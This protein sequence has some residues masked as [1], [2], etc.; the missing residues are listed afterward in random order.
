[1]DLGGKTEL[2]LGASTRS[3]TSFE[4]DQENRIL[5]K[6]EYLFRGGRCYVTS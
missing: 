6:T 1:M 4:G 2:K 3:D 5:W